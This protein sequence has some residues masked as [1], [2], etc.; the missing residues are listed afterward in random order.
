[1]TKDLHIGDIIRLLHQDFHRDDIMVVIKIV[2]HDEL[3]KEQY[4]ALSLKNRYSWTF[5]NYEGSY[6]EKL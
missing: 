6:Y 2:W 5:A 3:G 1:M 4:R